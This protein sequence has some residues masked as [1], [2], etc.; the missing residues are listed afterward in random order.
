M[1]VKFKCYTC[2]EDFNISDKYLAKKDSIVCP[3]CSSVLPEE[4]FK[5]LKEGVQLI[6]SSRDKQINQNTPAGYTPLFNFN[7]IDN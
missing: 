4:V 2:G 7:I 6:T 5:G 1:K 3:N